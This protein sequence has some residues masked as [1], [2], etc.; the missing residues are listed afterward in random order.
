MCWTFITL[1]KINT[2]RLNFVVFFFFFFAH[3]YIKFIMGIVQLHRNGSLQF[4]LVC[5]LISV[6]HMKSYNVICVCRVAQEIIFVKH[7]YRWCLIW[8]RYVQC[9]TCN[10]LS[11]QLLMRA[12]LLICGDFKFVAWKNYLYWSGKSIQSSFDV[13]IR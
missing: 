12:I 10:P 2:Y 4:F 5:V 11:G 1:V 13:S 8:A 6:L 9:D 7:Y 3:L